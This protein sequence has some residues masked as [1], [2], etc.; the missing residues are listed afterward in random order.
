MTVSLAIA[1]LLLYLKLFAYK[2]TGSTAI[3]S[4]A[5]ESMVHLAAVHIRLL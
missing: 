3:L 1:I 4:D 5:V 2:I